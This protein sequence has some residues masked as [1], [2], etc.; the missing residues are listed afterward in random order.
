M[1]SSILSITTK[2]KLNCYQVYKGG[3]TIKVKYSNKK[4]MLYLYSK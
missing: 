2:V 3:H 1:F 4:T